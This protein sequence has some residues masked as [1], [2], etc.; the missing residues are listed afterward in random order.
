MMRPLF[1]IAALF[2]ASPASAQQGSTQ[3]KPVTRAAVAAKLDSAFAAA[4]TNHDGFLSVAEVQAL[5][6]SELQKVQAA[7]RA[8]AEAQFKALD[9]NKDGQLSFQEFAAATP[10]VKA[11]DTPASLVQKLDTNHDGKISMAEFRAQRLAQFDKA[12]LNHD[13]IV[14]PDEERRAAAQK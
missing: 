4:D 8:R 2:L 6:N 5:E 3:P 1:L 14:T 13:G 7:L 12:D 10:N 9:T 11:T